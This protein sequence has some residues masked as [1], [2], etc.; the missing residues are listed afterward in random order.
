VAGHWDESVVIPCDIPYTPAYR[1]VSPTN[2]PM[3]L[4]PSLSAAKR[5]AWTC[6]VD[7]LYSVHV[8]F[9]FARPAMYMYIQC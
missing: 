3:P 2:P 1:V 8:F 5:R 9:G 6:T 7:N 4:P